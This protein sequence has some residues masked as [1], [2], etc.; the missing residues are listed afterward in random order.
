MPYLVY[1]GGFRGSDVITTLYRDKVN[2]LQGMGEFPY[3]EVRDTFSSYD[4][5]EED[6][7]EENEGDEDAE[8]PEFWTVEEVEDWDDLMTFTGLSMEEIAG[9]LPDD[10][11][12]EDGRME[13]IP[14]S[15]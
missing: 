3:D 15:D 14:F 6:W 10:I 12:G 2:A 11:D 9:E 13:S 8:E 4:I 7:R 1:D 5:D